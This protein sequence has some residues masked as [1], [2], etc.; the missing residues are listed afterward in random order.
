MKTLRSIIKEKIFDIREERDKEKKSFWCTES[1]TNQL[2]IFY[3]FKGIKPSNPMTPETQFG[4][5]IRTKVEDVILKYLDDIL[6]SPMPYTDSEGTLIENPDQ[7]R[8]EMER[9]GVPITGYID[10]LI[11][12]SVIENGVRK[13]EIVPVE[14]KTSYGPY[15][16]TELDRC[17]PKLPYLKQTAQYMDWLKENVNIF[18]PRLKEMFPDEK[19][20][21]K[22]ACNKGYLF[23]LHF[24]NNGFIPEDF[25]QFVLIR[26]GNKFKCGHVEFDLYEDVYKRYER[27]WNDYIVPNIEPES[28]FKYK[29]P[30]ESI[31]W[32]GLPK[33]KIAN[34]RNNKAV[35]GDWQIIYSDWK[36][37][38]IEKEGSQL[39]YS[40]EELTFI[41]QETKG[42]TTWFKAP[43][44]TGWAKL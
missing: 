16:K 10:S 37:M 15:A 2:E 12:E 29:Y 1:E 28:E 5:N 6:L 32:K 30:L 18:L 11:V 13:I 8:I 7:Q 22:I 21:L 36:D 42:Y 4:L 31:D 40:D 39:G 24:S 38:I 33:T 43:T 20:E 44:K 9:L 27:I 25:Y 41:N 17:E 35:I 19:C 34:A 3:K 26:D 14:I 23:Q